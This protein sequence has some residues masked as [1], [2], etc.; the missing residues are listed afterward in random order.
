MWRL[1]K[2]SNIV[3]RLEKRQVIR[4]MNEVESYRYVASF[5]VLL[6]YLHRN[7]DLTSA[8]LEKDNTSVNTETLKWFQQWL[9]KKID[10]YDEQRGGWKFDNAFN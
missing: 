5:E 9:S 6:E 4:N 10:Y 8:D 1:K 2:D 3:T 7:M